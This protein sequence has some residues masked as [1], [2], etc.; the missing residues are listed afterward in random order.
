MAQ[1]RRGER[2]LGPYPHAGKWRL[3]VVGLGGEKSRREYES[4]K[5]AERVKAGV[6]RELQVAEERT[7]AD[8]K[9]EYA[10]YLREEKQNKASALIVGH[11]LDKSPHGG[12][13]GALLCADQ[14]CEVSHNRP[15]CLRQTR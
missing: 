3:I 8:A 14:F 6:E 15:L 10:M 2:V 7:I 13:I 4:K 9:K 5:E 11:G 1:R 12:E